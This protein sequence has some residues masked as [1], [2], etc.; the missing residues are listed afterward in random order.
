MED[1]CCEDFCFHNSFIFSPYIFQE[2]PHG[3]HHGFHSELAAFPSGGQRQRYHGK[4]MPVINSHFWEKNN[5]T[6]WNKKTYSKLQL[7]L[8]VVSEVQDE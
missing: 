2:C 1:T 3:R 8:N 6:E 4:T 7:K 5:K